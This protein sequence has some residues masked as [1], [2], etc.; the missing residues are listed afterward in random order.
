MERLLQLPNT[1]STIKNKHINIIKRLWIYERDNKI[2]KIT[3]FN[4]VKLYLTINNNIKVIDEE[5]IKENIEDIERLFENKNKSQELIDIVEG[6]IGPCCSRFINKLSWYNIISIEPFNNRVYIDD[7]LVDKN[8][9]NIFLKLHSNTI[10]NDANNTKKE[11]KRLINIR[12]ELVEF[13][14]I[15]KQSITDKMILQIIKI[16]KENVDIFLLSIENNE[17]QSTIIANYFLL[18]ISKIINIV[19]LEQQTIDNI[20]KRVCQKWFSFIK[21]PRELDN[22]TYQIY[23]KDITKRLSAGYYIYN[24]TT[25]KGNNNIH[26]IYKRKLFKHLDFELN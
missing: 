13:K 14:R 23:I 20:S 3:L 2:H 25:H 12:N 11:R 17:P 6:Y 16:F 5:W 8:T 18:D 22:I 1:Y 9:L 24:N 26:P 15:S 4:K 7:K 19:L 21:K 10:L